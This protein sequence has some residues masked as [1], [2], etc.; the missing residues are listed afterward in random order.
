MSASGPQTVY[1][2]QLGLSTQTDRTS[3]RVP[4]LSFNYILTSWGLELPHIVYDCVGSS[5]YYLHPIVFM[6]CLNL[7]MDIAPQGVGLY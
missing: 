3:L 6:G 5:P 2:T 4:D 7:A 1:M